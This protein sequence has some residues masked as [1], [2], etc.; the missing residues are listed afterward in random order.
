MKELERC[1]KV[2]AR[3]VGELSDKGGGMRYRKK[4]GRGVAQDMH[5]DDPRLA[6]LLARCGELGLPINIH[7]A[8]PIWMYEP[9]DA[10]N[11]GLMNALDWRLDNKDVYSHA[12]MMDVLSNAVGR[13]PETTFVACHFANL[14]Y[15]LNQLGALLDRHPNLYADIAARYAE[16]AP[17]P[18]HAASFINRYQD[19]LLYGTDMGFDKEM[20][21]ITFRILESEDEHFYEKAQFGYHW[22]FHGFGLNSE[23]LKKLYRDNA[24]TIRARN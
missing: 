3:G 1:A 2:G 19:R 6:P 21:M 9:M 13:H 15:D 11:D 20:Y 16:T 22:A 10:R 18:R 7:V 12:A 14:S 5:F 8:E 4:G 17:I 24:L 23:V